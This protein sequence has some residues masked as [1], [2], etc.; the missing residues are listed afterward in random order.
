MPAARLL[1]SGK[2]E[3]IVVNTGDL[4]LYYFAKERPPRAYPIGIAK[5]GYATPLGVTVV[6]AKKEKPTWVP[7]ESAHR[8]DPT[9]AN[10]IPPGPT[11]PLG[12][13]ALYLGWPSYLI[14]GTNVPRG[15]GGTR[16]AAASP[17]S[18]G[19]RAALRAVPLG[20]P[21]AS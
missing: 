6:K 1:P 8:D 16:A 5:D 7:G 4:H 13:Y 20:R 14:H 18:G 19:H 17:V 3:G 10:A 2:R 15:W 12:E 21:C 9:A 11:N